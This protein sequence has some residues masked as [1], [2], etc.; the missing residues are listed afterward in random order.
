M[1]AAGKFTLAAAESEVRATAL[2]FGAAALEQLLCQPVLTGTAAP[3][4]SWRPAGHRQR[5]MLSVL[6]PI[7][8]TRQYYRDPANHRGYFP[9]DAALGL[10][11][12]SFS[13]GVQRMMA[14]VGANQSFGAAATELLEIAGLNVTPKEIERY[15]E[16]IGAAVATL[17]DGKE[18]PSTMPK[19][20]YVL[21]D[22]T[23]VPVTKAEATGHAGKNGG[24]AKTREVKL[25]CVFTQ[26]TTDD[27]GRPIRDE[28]STTYIGAIET[29][30]TFGPRLAAEVRRR[31]LEGAPRT[32]FL[33]D[34]AP[35]IWN[36]AYDHFPGATQIVDLYH[37]RE[38]YWDIAR[39]VFGP[40]SSELKPWCAERKKELDAGNVEALKAAIG[41]LKSRRGDLH[42]KIENAVEYF[43][44][45]RARMQYA[46][47]RQLGLFVGS[48]VVEAGCRTVVGQRLKCA[49]M[50]WT[51]RGANA[52]IALRCRIL[53]NRWDSI[54][55]R[56]L[57][58]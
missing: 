4:P 45:N 9:L 47:F 14:L 26:T 3:D 30:E 37:A 41:S 51:V 53:S 48:G 10:T 29:V 58:A 16:Q 5:Q 57:A 31:G 7:S 11:R 42:E 50:H 8:F 33:G 46:E 15:S 43:E 55:T 17:P 40:D 19:M 12:N 39:L 49:G 6:G 56:P 32:V 54:W 35:W 44:K 24:Q 52:I 20:V 22:G 36:L 25:G 34:G 27:E 23:G 1:A 38:H 28:K 18:M 2:R 13:P 21:G